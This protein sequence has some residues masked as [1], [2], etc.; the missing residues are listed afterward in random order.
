VWWREGR[1]GG[2]YTPKVQSEKHISFSH[3]VL[4]SLLVYIWQSGKSICKLPN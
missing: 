3:G 1:R 2:S 4:P